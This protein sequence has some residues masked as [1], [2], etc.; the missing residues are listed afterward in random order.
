MFSGQQGIYYNYQPVID[1]KKCKKFIPQSHQTECLDY[2][3]NSI[4]D[5]KDIKGLLLYHR[6]GSGKT[7]TS[8]MIANKLLIEKKINHVYIMI[9][10][11]LREGWIKEYISVCGFSTELLQKKYIFV[12][13]NYRV[14]KRIDKLDLNNTLVIIDEVHNLINGYKNQSLNPTLLYNKLKNSNCKIL[15]LSGT[16]VYNNIYDFSFLK[17]L[18]KPTNKPLVTIVKDKIFSNKFDIRFKHEPDGSVTPKNITTFKKLMS[19]FISYFPGSGKD[20][21]PE[22]KHMEPFRIEMSPQ[23]L[24]YY[25]N[26]V[27]TEKAYGS[28][29]PSLNLKH[30]NPNLYKLLEELYIMAKKHI[31]TRSGVNFYYPTI[32]EK[33]PDNEIKKGG[34]VTKPMFSNKKI[35]I[36]SGK[37]AVLFF[38]IIKHPKQKHVVFTF[39]KQKAGVN[40]IRSMLNMCGVSNIIFSGDLSDSERKNTLKRFNDTSN[41]YGENISVILVTEAGAEGITIKEARHFHIL[42]SSPTPTK[43]QQAIGRV[44]RYKSHSMMPKEEQNVKIWRYWSITNI[45]TPIK[46]SH[47]TL[48]GKGQ[49]KDYLFDRNVESIDV[50]LYKSGQK[51]LRNV[52]TF[53]DYI[54]LSSVTKYTE[55]ENDNKVVDLQGTKILSLYN[56]EDFKEFKDI[57]SVQ[58]LLDETERLFTKLA[59]VHFPQNIIKPE[60]GSNIQEGQ[61]NKAPEPNTLSKLSSEVDISPTDQNISEK[62]KDI[63]DISTSETEIS[64]VE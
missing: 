51:K 2:F 10:G 43:I 61:D 33:I 37:L 57:G 3:M 21:Y 29:K 34:W 13:Y 52:A 39:F 6:L 62:E 5:S 45:K 32:V 50:T 8:L 1:T 58:D 41:R 16:P 17:D 26:K 56:Q 4:L 49:T 25:L 38:N 28:R 53:L 22:V 42:E 59:L 48:M 46:I 63:T 54:K 55:N 14:G 18:L 30:K 20:L 12:T 64:G 9:P 19:G 36:L 44:V 7:A 31:M 15:A 11:S 40:L 24:H 47:S 60:E 27:V 23:Q 35:Y